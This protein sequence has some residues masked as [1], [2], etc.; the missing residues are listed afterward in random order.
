MAAVDACRAPLAQ[1]PSRPF[2]EEAMKQTALAHLEEYL[3]RP[4]DDKPF[5]AED[6]QKERDRLWQNWTRFCETV[7]I[8]NRTAWLRFVAHPETADAQAFFKSF[9]RIY[10]ETSA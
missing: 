8:D 10:A 4:V 1:Y 2:S 3:S 7:S 6:T 9:L 5:V